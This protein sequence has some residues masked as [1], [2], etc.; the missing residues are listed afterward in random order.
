MKPVD[1]MTVRRLALEALADTRSVAKELR[2][3]RV[4]GV[5][6]ERIRHVLDQ[7]G[8]RKSAR[9]VDEYDELN[10]LRLARRAKRA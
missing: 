5:V 7:H 8:L 6:G 3:E 4:R 10:P 1:T 9:L 2:G